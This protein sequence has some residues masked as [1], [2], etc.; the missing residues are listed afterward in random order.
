MG[1]LQLMP[2]FWETHGAIMCLVMKQKGI[3]KC[4]EIMKQKGIKK[5]EY[6]ENEGTFKKNIL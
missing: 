3:K 4:A 2:R 5:C 6:I 1:K